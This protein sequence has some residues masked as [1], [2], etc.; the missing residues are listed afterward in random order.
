MTK[1][2]I[3]KQYK[4]QASGQEN[5]N[6]MI[7]DRCIIKSIPPTW[8]HMNKVEFKYPPKPANIYIQIDTHMYMYWYLLE[9]MGH[10]TEF[11]IKFD[12]KLISNSYLCW[13]IYD[14]ITSSKNKNGYD[15]SKGLEYCE[16]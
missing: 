8:A 10:G 9:E 2:I 13:S 7:N 11:T 5:Q 1:Y 6:H 3:Q 4:V 14:S 16:G 15:F 12:L